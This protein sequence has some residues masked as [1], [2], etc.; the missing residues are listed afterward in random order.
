MRSPFDDAELYDWEYRRRR[1]DVR[2]Y[3]TLADERGGPILDVGC[4]TG[5]LLLPLLRAGHQV[6]GVDL[7]PAMLAR[8]AA[9]VA[10]LSAAHRRRALLLRGD[11]RGLPCGPRF[12]FAVAAFHTVQHCE[13]N[14]DLLRFFR[15][16]AASLQPGGWLAF[17]TFAP[18][19]RFLERRGPSGHTRFRDPR[20][21]RPTI[22]SES[23]VVEPGPDGPILAMTFHYR[24]VDAADRPRGRARHLSLRHRLLQPV[25]IQ[26]LLREAGLAPIA[27]WGGFDGRPLIAS[28][29]QTEQHVYLA[30]RPRGQEMF[31]EM[32]EGKT[33]EKPKAKPREK[34]QKALQKAQTDVG[35]RREYRL[36]GPR[37]PIRCSRVFANFL[38]EGCRD[39]GESRKAGCRA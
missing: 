35:V 29:R 15:S 31:E 36:T 39:G 24:P 9:R 11:L 5:R 18:D 8:A 23:H 4:G 27:S 1:A 33:R 13:S 30:Q 19:P 14:A 12:A 37:P 22:Y 2:F 3:Q 20:T 17:D 34:P 32:F 7:A 21:A 38:T 26:T 16:A 25:E 6:V 10:R 28:D